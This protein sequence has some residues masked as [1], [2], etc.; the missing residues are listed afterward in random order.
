MN[1]FFGID[2]ITVILVIC[3][4][5]YTLLL[6]KNMIRM[7]IGYELMTKGVT[8]AFISAGNAN[9]RIALSQT[10]VI[11]MIVVEVVSIAT[12]LAIVMLIQKKNHSLN[13]R[14]LTNLKG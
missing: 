4:G 14:K 3:I 2:F 11:T 8:L 6:A 12:A 9:G 13:I 10:L 1:N 5:L 7:L